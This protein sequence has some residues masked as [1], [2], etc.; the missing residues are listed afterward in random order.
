MAGYDRVFG[1]VREEVNQL[2]EEGREI[3]R[4]KYLE[5]IN[6]NAENKAKLMEIYDSL[7]ALPMRSD[8]KYNEPSE[9]EEI[10]A[11]SDIS[12]LPDDK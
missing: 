5:L 11:E 10:Y 4:E 12:T 3:D 1:L 8:Y 2:F 6:A 9:L 7:C